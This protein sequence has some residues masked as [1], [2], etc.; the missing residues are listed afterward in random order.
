MPHY[1]AV[2][3]LPRKRHTRSPWCEELMGEHGFSGA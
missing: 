1:R 2:G 3:E